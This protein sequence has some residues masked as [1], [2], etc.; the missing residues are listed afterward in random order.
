M[1]RTLR[2]IALLLSIL[3][4]CSCTVQPDPDGSSSEESLLDPT[5]ST[6]PAE[7]DW[8]VW[9]EDHSAQVELIPS[10]ATERNRELAAALY[11][12]FLSTPPIDFVYGNEVFSEHLSD[13]ERTETASDDGAA[14]SYTHLATLLTVT[15]DYRFYDD[16]SALEWGVRLENKGAEKTLQ[17]E[18]FRTL[19]FKADSKSNTKLLYSKG[20]NATEDDFA[21][22]TDA[23]KDGETC[24]IFPAG[25]RSSSGVMPFFNLYTAKDAGFIGAIGWSGQWALQAE[26]NDGTVTV[27]SGMSDSRFYLN[28]G[29]SVMQPTMIF[30]PWK[31]DA[32]E[33]HNDLRRHILAHHT[34]RMED[35]GLPVGPISYGVW[36]GDGSQA[37]ID[38]IK[39]IDNTD[40][41]FDALWID[42]GWYG[43]D[44]A[45][46]QNTFDSIWNENVGTWDVVPSL[47]P[48]GMKEVSAA[49]HE[50]GVALVLWFEPE[51]AFKGTKLVTEH[52]DYFLTNS[53]NPDYFLFNLGNEEARLWLTD[54]IAGLIKE[55]GVDIYRQD[56][57]IEPLDYWRTADPMDR[58]GVTEMKYIEGLYL[59]WDGLLERCPGVVIDNCASGGRR[60]DFEA[61]SRSVALFRT[62]Y[63]CDAVNATAEGSQMEWYGLNFWLPLHGTSAMGR[64]DSYNFRSTFGFSVQSPSVL[65]KAKDQEPLNREFRELSPYCYGDYYPLTECTSDQTG[66]F[67]YQMNRRD[68]ESG[69]I[70]AFRRLHADSSFITVSLSGLDEDATYR[71]TVTDTGEVYEATGLEL[72]DGGLTIYIDW[73]KESRVVLYEKVN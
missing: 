65:G 31:G 25:G 43:S 49:A 72:M 21:P 51:R 61:L 47:Y 13:W 6:E 71:V 42:A 20:G 11:E 19:S 67:A 14:V 22:Q 30:L 68:L 23:L 66:W 59:F 58:I 24:K 48:N 46:S 12:I 50:A 8:T 5:E 38:K 60:L 63:V 9:L 2:W 37:H 29:E 36:G 44:D 41:G 32:Q 15:I 52:P 26:K 7:K 53:S 10:A 69:F 55:Y 39:A 73:N 54:Y 62:D 56:F 27:E 35:G 34:P 1:K 45:I 17:I 18:N 3:L 64:T 40:M 33:A 4:L 57:N 28:A 16:T 70:C